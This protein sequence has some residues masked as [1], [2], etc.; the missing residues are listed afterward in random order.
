MFTWT[1]SKSFAVA[2]LFAILIQ[3]VGVSYATTPSQFK[4]SPLRFGLNQL[5]DCPLYPIALS[6]DSLVGVNSGDVLADIYNGTRP[7]NFGWLSWAGSPNEPTLVNSLTPPGNSDTF[8]NPNDTADHLVSIGDWVSG[9]PGVTNSAAVRQA[10]TTLKTVD[11]VVPVWAA[12]TASGHNTLYQVAD[13]ARV[14]ITDFQLPQ[15]NRISAIFLGFGCSSE[16]PTP[17]ETATPTDTPTETE[18]VTPTDT[19]TD[20]PTPT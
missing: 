15:Q 3:F 11:I 20:T 7:G 9:K 2:L 6:I 19:P 8:V 14:R 18:T 16:T 4:S 13:F 5:D 10:L 1:K 12:T 17:T